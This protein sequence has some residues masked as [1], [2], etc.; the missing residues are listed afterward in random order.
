MRRFLARKCCYRMGCWCRLRCRDPLRS[1][2]YRHW[3]FRCPFRWPVRFQ[4]V[5]YRCRQR[6]PTG[7]SIAP[8]E[9]LRAVVQATLLR[10]AVRV[11]LLRTVVQATLLR[12]AVRVKLLRTV[13]RPSRHRSAVRAR[14]L[15]S[16]VRVKLH[17]TVVRVKLHRIV[18]R[19]KLLRSAVRVKLLRSAVRARLRRTAVRPSRHRIAFRSN[20]RIVALP[21]RH[22]I[23]VRSNQLPPVG[24]FF[25]LCVFVWFSKWINEKYHTKTMHISDTPV[26]ASIHPF[27][28]DGRSA[29]E[30]LIHFWWHHWW[31]TLTCQWNWIGERDGL[32]LTESTDLRRCSGDG[33]ADQG[34]HQQSKHLQTDQHRMIIPRLIE[35][36][37]NRQKERERERERESGDAEFT[38]AMLWAMDWLVQLEI[39]DGRM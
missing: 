32:K 38:L 9:L 31:I 39:V 6:W 28:T 5:R 27:E 15:R 35:A 4:P 1:R 34:R 25:V 17:R 33:E 21:N 11:K 7:R 12:F 29:D 30:P 2:C 23:V 36:H 10:F 13:V 16:A 3:R 24:L 26:I 18:V 22:R 20:L 19:V 14:P 8:V 37:T